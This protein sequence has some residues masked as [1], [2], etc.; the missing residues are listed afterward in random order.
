MSDPTLDALEDLAREVD[1]LAAASDAAS[2]ARASARRQR[3]LIELDVAGLLTGEPEIGARVAHHPTLR[4][5]HDACVALAD[6]HASAA[7]KRWLEGSVPAGPQQARVSL[8][9]F[10]TP[11]PYVPP[12][13]LPHAWLALCERNFI[14]PLPQ[15]TGTRF[16]RLEG[17]LHALHFRTEVDREPRLWRAEPEITTRSKRLAQDILDELD[18]PI[19]NER[20]A[21]LARKEEEDRASLERFYVTSGQAEPEAI[22]ARRLTE[23]VD[24]IERADPPRTGTFAPI[25]MSFPMPGRRAALRF[26]A[27]PSKAE[28]RYVEL[29]VGTPSGISTSSS[30][31]DIGTH[32]DL[33]AWLRTS[34]AL[35][36]A[37]R[38]F[39]GALESLERNR[40]A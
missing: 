7:R 33:L 30:W 24:A 23:L 9:W 16:V 20:A 40:L 39:A 34:E 32:D 21:Q 2:I 3:L 6:Y 22:L 19:S 18:R 26:A 1:R 38:A 4:G 10:R 8:D 5:Y 17:A 36:A 11:S 12:G 37:V 27:S 15:G 13:V 35:A 29:S 25:E 14:D 28:R 31:L